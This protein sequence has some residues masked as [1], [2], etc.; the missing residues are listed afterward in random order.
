MDMARNLGKGERMIRLLIGI[1]LIPLGFALTGIW[2]IC[3]IV[4]GLGLI[5]TSLMG[6]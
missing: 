6:Y 1:V 3:A 4:V 2:K 5:L